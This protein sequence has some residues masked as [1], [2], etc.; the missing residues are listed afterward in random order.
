MRQ[1]DWLALV[2]VSDCEDELDNL[3]RELHDLRRH[4]DWVRVVA[5]VRPPAYGEAL[6]LVSPAQK[7]RPL[8]SG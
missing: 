2:P 3:M 7:H 4:V 5:A 6:S 8:P 1:D